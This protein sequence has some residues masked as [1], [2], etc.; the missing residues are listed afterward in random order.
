MQPG[1]LLFWDGQGS[2]YHVAIYLG[3]N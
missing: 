1:D 2:A 3:Y